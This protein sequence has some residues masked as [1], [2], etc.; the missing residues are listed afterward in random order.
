M[1]ICGGRSTVYQACVGEE[2]CRKSSQV[3]FVRC[4]QEGN[5]GHTE[6]KIVDTVEEI[7]E[8]RGNE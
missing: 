2:Q 6:R 8:Y 7:V 5:I 4:Y 3:E 1:S